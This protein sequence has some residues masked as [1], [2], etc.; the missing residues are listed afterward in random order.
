VFIGTVAE[1]RGVSPEDVMENFGAG[2]MMIAEDAIKAGMADSFGS[3]EFLISALS[4]GRTFLPQSRQ[5]LL[6]M[7]KITKE[8]LSAE[9]PDVFKAVHD[10]AFELGL[11]AGKLQ[12]FAERARIQSIDALDT[13]GHDALIAA[14][15]FDG[16]STAGDVA[17]LINAAEKT[18]RAEMA[19]NI[20]A[21]TP[22]PVPHAQAAFNDGTG[23]ATEQ[24]TGEDKWTADWK[25]NAAIQSEFNNISAYVAYQKANARGLVKTLGAK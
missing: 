5:G 14:A 16:K 22:K 12:G 6:T 13:F 15:K 3:M 1:Y 18:H 9:A 2:G 17:I 23:E 11:T 24:L 4:G 25:S 7:N 21:D 20:T 8:S 19:A 10:E